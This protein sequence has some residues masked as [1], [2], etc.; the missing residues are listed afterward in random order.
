[1]PKIWDMIPKETKTKVMA[2][3]HYLEKIEG[4][5]TMTRREDNKLVFEQEDLNTVL[6][7]VIKDNQFRHGNEMP[8]TIV[9]E[10][11]ACATGKDRNDVEYAV[12]IKVRI[13]ESD[14]PEET[15]PPVP[16][17][18]GRKAAELKKALEDAKEVGLGG[19]QGKEL[20]GLHVLAR[21][22]PN[23]EGIEFKPIPISDKDREF[24]ELAKAVRQRGT[25]STVVPTEDIIYYCLK[26]KCKHNP[27]KRLHKKH[28]K[29]K[30]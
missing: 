19:T 3:R 30:Q 20:D 23:D 15:L 1:M 24:V 6:A 11:P 10:V 29:Y 17:E 9:V 18:V 22:A 28:L 8:E 14:E 4:G 13:S 12:P 25:G 26:C 21:L 27:G 7:Y 16:D 2:Y 5:K